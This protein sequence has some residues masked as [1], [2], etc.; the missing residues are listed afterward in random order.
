MLLYIIFISLS[1]LLSLSLC[2]DYF[3]GAAAVVLSVLW[4]RSAAAVLLS[5]VSAAVC[6]NFLRLLCALHIGNAQRLPV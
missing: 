6:S 4:L 1:L 2:A 5:A 3:Y